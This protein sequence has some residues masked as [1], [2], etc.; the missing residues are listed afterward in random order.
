MINFLYN[1]GEK[2]AVLTEKVKCITKVKIN[3]LSISLAS[4]KDVKLKSEG[5]SL[6]LEKLGKRLR[7]P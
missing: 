5:A 6:I 3:L 4:N 1:R 2:S 7:S